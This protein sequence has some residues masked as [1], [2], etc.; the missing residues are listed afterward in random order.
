[1]P[2]WIEQGHLR[3]AFL[4]DGKS[5]E[6]CSTHAL[7]T[8]KSFLRDM[9]ANEVYGR[10]DVMCMRGDALLTFHTC[11]NVAVFRSPLALLQ[12]VAADKSKA[13]PS[14]E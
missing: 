11:E 6:E 7:E 13:A 2:P 3:Y 4:I 8:T 12:V 10:K 9:E 5:K 14:Q 1:M